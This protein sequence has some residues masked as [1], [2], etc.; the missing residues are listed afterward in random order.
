MNKQKHNKM[1][2][3]V[4]IEYLENDITIFFTFVFFLLVYNPQKSRRHKENLKIMILIDARLMKSTWRTKFD[5]P[6]TYPRYKALFKFI[7]I[8][9]DT[10]KIDRT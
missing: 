2:S 3:N 9:R 1:Y 8:N 4:M 6:L 5:W 7:A 10:S